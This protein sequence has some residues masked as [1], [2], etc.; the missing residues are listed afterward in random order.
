MGPSPSHHATT[1][2]G[3]VTAAG[4]KASGA[5][6]TGWH[7]RFAPGEAKTGVVDDE[8]HA[9]L[10]VQLLLELIGPGQSLR[11]WIWLEPYQSLGKI[12]TGS[13]ID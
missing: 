7:Q 13:R 10:V 11:P 3:G 1:S 5:R 4:V 12:R 9:A 6:V 2:T 8:L